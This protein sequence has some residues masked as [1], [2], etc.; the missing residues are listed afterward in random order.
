MG[1][2]GGQLSYWSHRWDRLVRV[3]RCQGAGLDRSPGRRSAP[4]SACTETEERHCGPRRAV[5]DLN[6]RKCPEHQ[7]A[8]DNPAHKFDHDPRAS[9]LFSIATSAATGRGGQGSSA[10]AAASTEAGGT[11]KAGN[12]V[13][14]NHRGGRRRA[15]RLVR[16]PWQELVALETP[17]GSKKLG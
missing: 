9:A 10:T 5:R 1:H 16:G 2:R 15:D 17:Q 6:P 13:G 7:S 11:R 4:G 3:L 12:L 14:W 8:V